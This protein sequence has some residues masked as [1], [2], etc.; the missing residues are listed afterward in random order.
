MILLFN[1]TI[2]CFS[3]V[4][5]PFFFVLFNCFTF[6]FAFSPLFLPFN[7]L[8]SNEKLKPTPRISSRQI[9][10]LPPIRQRHRP[11]RQPLIRH[12]VRPPHIHP[13]GIDRAHAVLGSICVF[14]ANP[15]GEAVAV[16][17]ILGCAYVDG[18]WRVGE[19]E[20][21]GEE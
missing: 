10:R 20:G 1:S 4:L 3:P 18:S 16:W 7:L 6:P 2:F 15:G 9:N 17:A 5:P 12:I 13:E 11:H 19:G 21:G 8:P 14:G